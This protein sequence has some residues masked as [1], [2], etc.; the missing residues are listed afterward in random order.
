MTRH[1][2]SNVNVLLHGFGSA[3]V[4]FRHFLELAQQERPDI[5]WHIILPSSTHMKLMLEVLPKENILSVEDELPRSPQGCDLSEL[6]NYKGSLIEDL[7]AQKRSWF[8]RSGDKFYKRGQDYYKLYKNYMLAKNITHFL[9]LTI[10]TPEMKIAMA[11]AQELGIDASYAANLRN[12]TGT[13]FSTTAYETLPSYNSC[14]E[15]S[16]NAAKEYI[17]AFRQ[18]PLPAFALPKD[19]PA[20]SDSDKL[21]DTFVPPAN[22]RL[23]QKIHQTLKRP[24]LFEPDA[25]RVSFLNNL[26]CLR[27]KYWDIRSA[28]NNSFANI[29]DI[30]DLPE[31]FILYPLQVTPESS[32]NVPAPYYVDQ[33]RIIDALRM[34]MPND[35][36]LVVKEH[37]SAAPVRSI[38]F[39]RRLRNLPGVKIASH[40]LPSFEILKRASLLATITGTMALEAFT[41]GLPAI[42]FGRGFC[43]DMHGGTTGTKDLDKII[44]S[45]IMTKIPDETVIETLSKYFSCRYPFVIGSSGMVGEPILRKGNIDSF[46]KAYMD[47]IE[48]ITQNS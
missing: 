43:A 47:H 46:F 16:V 39:M 22:S 15:D 21:L 6:E 20:A 41:L 7:E 4:V 10:E 9:C 26:P 18:A 45:K 27:D 42:V 30:N 32:I 31:K 8:K 48:R 12:M 40:K 11:T 13:M 37:R 44:S 38:Q 17:T 28:I 19:A 35:Y 2:N 23:K 14:T 5:T 29:H 33:L 3:P 34:E 1:N 24:D 25:I 36:T